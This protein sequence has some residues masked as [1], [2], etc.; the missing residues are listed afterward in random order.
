MLGTEIRC[1]T[2][3]YFFNYRYWI[4][5]PDKRSNWLHK[6][7]VH[8]TTHKIENQAGCSKKGNPIQK[9]LNPVKNSG[10][11]KQYENNVKAYQPYINNFLSQ[12]ISTKDLSELYKNN[13]YILT[14]FTTNENQY[15]YSISQGWLHCS[16]VDTL[17][18]D[19]DNYSYLNIS[20]S[21]LAK[22]LPYVSLF[23]YSTGHAIK[24]GG[25]YTGI[26][27]FVDLKEPINYSPFNTDEYNYV[28]MQIFNQIEND[29]KS[30]FTVDINK[31]SILDVAMISRGRLNYGINIHQKINAEYNVYYQ[32]VVF[33]NSTIKFIPEPQQI[34]TK[35]NATVVADKNSKD[36]LEWLFNAT[37]DNASYD[38]KEADYQLITD[39]QDHLIML[40]SS[41]N[42]P[43]DRWCIEVKN[44]IQYYYYGADTSNPKLR[45]PMDKARMQDRILASGYIRK[46]ISRLF[47]G[48]QA[49]YA[50][51]L[52]DVKHYKLLDNLID[53]C[54]QYRNEMQKSTVSYKVARCRADS[55]FTN[56]KLQCV[57][58]GFGWLADKIHNNKDKNNVF[59]QFKVLFNQDLQQ[60]KKLVIKLRNLTSTPIKNDNNLQLDFVS[61]TIDVELTTDKIE[62]LITEF[63]LN[64]T[65]Y[66]FGKLFLCESKGLYLSVIKNGV[67]SKQKLTGRV[68]KQITLLQILEFIKD[69]EKILTDTNRYD[70][71]KAFNS[72]VARD[73]NIDFEKE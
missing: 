6:L 60:I 41:G 49:K 43:Y 15:N 17:I 57:A 14:Q 12:K 67:E 23:T 21:E 71:F 66:E 18:F 51:N 31:D 2:M 32:D 11:Q 42:L 20:L 9:F 22:K 3:I 46:M 48:I 26:K 19:I 27:L 25:C 34:N 7:Q 8:P 1:K 63:K 72:I 64:M 53:E 45:P 55:D 10:N 47:F 54:R 39:I 36:Y 62:A 16:V 29:L 33:D 70:I 69:L 59:Q 52:L 61:L 35:N 65:P 38:I 40:K 28:Y 73:L 50:T 13:P 68:I 24:N 30:L 5:T 44:T 4:I 56:F 58:G 37:A